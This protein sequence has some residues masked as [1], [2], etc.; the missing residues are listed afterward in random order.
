MRSLRGNAGHMHRERRYRQA[1]LVVLFAPPTSDAHYDDYSKDKGSGGSFSK[2]FIII[3]LVII[4]IINVH[5]LNAHHGHDDDN[6]DSKKR[7]LWR[8]LLLLNRSVS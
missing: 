1:Y 7:G 5:H 4:V 6:A 2:M 8:F 3:M